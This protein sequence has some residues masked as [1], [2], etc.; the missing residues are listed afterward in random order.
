M[1][2]S[3]SIQYDNLSNALN[4][5]YKLLQVNSPKK[6]IFNEAKSLSLYHGKI[7]GILMARNVKN[8]NI[9]NSQMNDIIN[10]RMAISHLKDGPE[11][12]ERQKQDVINAISKVLDNIERLKSIG[13]HKGLYSKGGK[14]RTHKR[15]HIRHKT[16]KHRN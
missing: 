10:L 9:P 6:D 14:R 2:D 11:R 3:F 4:T 13:K 7:I 15:R 12:T 16:R 5:I 8:T 1:S